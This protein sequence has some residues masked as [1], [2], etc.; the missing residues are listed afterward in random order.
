M[1]QRRHCLAAL[2]ALG[3]S[4]LLPAFGQQDFPSKPI[5]L[6]VPFSA[7]GSP[8]LL[9][10]L[11]AAQAGKQ[12]GQG[13][14]VENRLGA[15]GIVAAEA[16]ARAAPDGYTLLVTTGSQAINPSIYKSLPYDTLA[17]FAPVSL[18]S[19]APALTLVV[20]PDSPIKTFKEFL[21]IAR[22]PDGNVSFGSPGT[23]N[24]LHL[25]GELLNVMAGTRMLHVPYKGAAPALNAVMGKEVTA[26]F[27]S[28]TA[29]TMAVKAGQVRPL[30]VTSAKRMAG[31]P[32]VPTMAESGV[33]DM[34]YNGGWVGLF[35]PGKTPAPVVQKLSAEINRAMQ[36]PQ[37]KEKML[38]WDSPPASYTPDEFGRFF[39]QEMDKFSRIVKLANVP[40]Q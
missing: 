29:A 28:T 40:M 39:R 36:E 19:V 20:A 32:D 2:G 21:E 18:F 10:R 17:D 5:R 6:L 27:L 23:G 22:R 25:A 3:A 7:G 37:V 26:C 24:T 14:V 34:D 9:A 30:A 13:M 12:M 16:V 1:I 35:A 38:S 8:D 33:P 15:N 31:F 4:H 11:I